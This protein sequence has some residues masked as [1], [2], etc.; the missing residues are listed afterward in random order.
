VPGDVRSDIHRNLATTD[1]EASI[2]R[3]EIEQPNFELK[4]GLLPLDASRSLQ[5][6]IFDKITRTI[7]AIANNGANRS[8]K[9]IIGVTDKDVDATRI[10]ALDGI[11]PKKIGR[12]YIVGINRE[13]GALGISIEQYMQKFRDAVKNSS[14]SEPL[15][16]SVLSNIEFNAFYGF[17]VL[18]INI[19]PQK[20]LSYWG[21]EVY[22]REGDA[23]V[24]AREAKK[25]VELSQ[26]FVSS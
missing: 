9:I 10:K 6:E 13:A 20:D 19:L 24:V 2:R 14:V 25:I 1:I 11:E 3:S 26:R 21:Q 16:G 4:Q 18:V 15:R 7:C 5:R 17:G 22:W 8:G 23:T 12:R